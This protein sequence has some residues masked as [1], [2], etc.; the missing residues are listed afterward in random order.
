[1]R[2]A[3]VPA[4]RVEDGVG[5]EHARAHHLIGCR[6]GRQA[7]E[8]APRCSDAS[9]VSSRPVCYRTGLGRFG[10]ETGGRRVAVGG[11]PSGTRAGISVKVG[12]GPLGTVAAGARGTG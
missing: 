8:R 12:G 3:P 11:G 4:G 7:I 10:Y 2:T 1:M 5:A 9:S 6:A